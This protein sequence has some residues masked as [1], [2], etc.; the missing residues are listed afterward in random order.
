MTPPKGIYL[1]RPQ[2]L[3]L[4]IAQRL[5]TCC[6]LVTPYDDKNLSQQ[7]LRLWL[8][9]CRSSVRYIDIQL[10]AITQDIPEPSITKMKF[11]IICLKF[12]SYLAAAHWLIMVKSEF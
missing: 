3:D 6:G 12:H 2:R 8:V 10:L 1:T 5:S 11:E 7:W 9:S 4:I